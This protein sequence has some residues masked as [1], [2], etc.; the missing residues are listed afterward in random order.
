MNRLEFS[1]Q[2]R[3]WRAGLARPIDLAIPLDFAGPQPRFF[4]DFAATAEPLRAGAFTG[5]VAEGASCNCA[6]YTLAPHCHGTHT[7]CL[8]HV[9]APAASLASFTPVPP[10]LALLVSAE[11]RPL[12]AEAVGA[13]AAADDPVIDR[14]SLER[15]AAAWLQAPWTALV[16]RTLPNGPAKR[17]RAY[18]GAC[19][20]PYFRPDAVA[21]LVERGVSSLVVDLPSLDRA[22]DGGALAAHRL[23]WGLPAGSSDARAATRAHA[24]VTELAYVPDDVHDG[25]YLLD[26]QVPAFVADAAPSRPVLYALVESTQEPTA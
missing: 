7:E 5:S 8:G 16:L 12:G 20:A 13:H 18:A 10:A 3:R 11:P 17:Y 2:G 14:R 6:A 9:S 23:Y 15:A 1:V 21:W 4:A 22:D 26:L 25:L 19:P 24:L